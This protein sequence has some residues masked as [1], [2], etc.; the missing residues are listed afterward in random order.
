M[1]IFQNHL[2]GAAAAAAAGGGG[3]YNHQIE[4]SARFDRASESYLNRNFTS[5]G[6][7]KVFTYSVWVKLSSISDSSYGQSIVTGSSNNNTIAFYLGYWYIQR[8]NNLFGSS[9]GPLYRDYSS[10]MHIV[11][12]FDI[13]NGTNAEK[14][15]VYV[16]G[17]EVTT[18]GTDQR[19]S[20]S[21]DST[22][23]TGQNYIGKTTQNTATAFDG[24]MAEFIFI[25]GQQLT[26]SS[27]GETKNGVWIPKD[28]SGL[29]FGSNGYHLKFENAS[30]L[31]N[32]SS[33]NNNDFT[34]NNMGTDH[35]VSDS[36]TFG[37]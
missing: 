2:M 28:P 21:G 30:D 22:F 33:G 26:P 11:V 27:F 37:S 19:S 4:Q 14:I 17:T 32:D 13:D 7:L 20:L 35:Q 10:W 9:S 1:G 23:N 25:D 3:F 34:A 24:Y 12:A 36:P 29:T 8:S 5:A 18:W 15:R 31:G 6:N 16:N